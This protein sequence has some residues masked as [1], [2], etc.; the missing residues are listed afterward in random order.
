VCI[1]IVVILLVLGIRSLSADLEHVQF[2][3]YD[4]EIFVVPMFVNITSQATRNT[5]YVGM[6]I[7]CLSV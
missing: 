7:V 4:L 6:F 5:Q 3:R 1:N 2:F